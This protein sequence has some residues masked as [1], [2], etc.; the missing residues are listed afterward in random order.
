MDFV[1]DAVV[2]G[3]DHGEEPFTADQAADQT[4]ATKENR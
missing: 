4:A 3:Q 2:E 1:P